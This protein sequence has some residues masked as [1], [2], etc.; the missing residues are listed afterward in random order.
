[1]PEPIDTR[2]T[3][4]RNVLKAAWAIP[5]VIALGSIPAMGQVASGPQPS[6]C[7][8]VHDYDTDEYV[9]VI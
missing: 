1:M 7:E 4:R 5:A 6:P 2:S 9:C 8:E 3:T